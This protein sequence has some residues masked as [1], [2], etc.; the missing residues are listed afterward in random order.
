MISFKNDY[1]EGTHENILKALT[2]INLD[3]YDGYGDDRITS[4]TTERMAIEL[5][6][7]K[8]CIH[9]LSGGTQANLTFIS[10]A[11]RPFQAVISAD[12]G[13]IATHEA[14]AIEATGH[15][16]IE[17]PNADG[18]LTVD[19]IKQA[20]AVN[21]FPPHTVQPKLVYISQPTEWGTLY[22]KEELEAISNY[23]KHNDMFLYI[24]GA[25]LSSALYAQMDSLSLLDYKHLC[26]AILIG[27]TKCG[28]LFGE[29]LV[30]FNEYINYNFKY[31]LKQ[32]GALMAKGRLISLQFNELF[33]DHCNLYLTMAKHANS[34][35][36]YLKESLK[37]AGFEFYCD[38][39]TN[40]QFPIFSND[41]INH[42]E[43]QFGITFMQ[44]HN[45]NTS[46]IRCVTSFATK[47]Q[48]IDLFV[49]ACKK[50]S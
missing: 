30:I 28:A 1:S 27:G 35:S 5:E 46:V 6:C 9:F 26:D 12:S 40:Q 21:S 33:K 13:H 48:N 17:M 4:K 16:V 36:I 38:S 25:R 42:L 18:K 49:D 19:L 32:R 29:S 43:H 8:N 22:S 45:D 44:P 39:I 50:L 20:N 23:C 34:M 2:A 31:S 41:L 24:D 10:H 37:E 3:Q 11:L 14:G 15:K 47:K 7:N